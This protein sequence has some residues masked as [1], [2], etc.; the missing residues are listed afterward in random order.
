MKKS[1]FNA[2]AVQIGGRGSVISQARYIRKS[3]CVDVIS[4]SA[5]KG[6]WMATNHREQCPWKDGAGEGNEWIYSLIK[7][8][9]LSHLVIKQQQPAHDPISA[10]S[11]PSEFDGK[12]VFPGYPNPQSGVIY[13]S[14]PEINDKM[15]AHTVCL[16]K[17]W[18]ATQ[19]WGTLIEVLSNAPIVYDYVM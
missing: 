5:N 15:A 3:P 18:E 11:S 14:A 10:S 19:Q 4:A 9:I 8:G 12:K 6:R 1:I 13:E 17:K 7:Q 2:K 16:L